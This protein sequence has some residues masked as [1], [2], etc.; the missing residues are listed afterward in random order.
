MSFEPLYIESWIYATLHDDDTLTEA[1]ADVEGNAPGYQQGVYMHL[2]P[3][4]DRVS[5]SAPQVPYIVVT[6]EDMGDESMAIE[7][8][9][10]LVEFD[11]QVTIWDSQNGAVAMDRLL[12]IADRVDTLLHKQ[13]ATQSGVKLFSRRIGTGTEIEPLQGGEVFYG[14][15]A[16][17]RFQTG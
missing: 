13:T 10:A 6:R 1:L 11:Y 3:Q 17:Y 4:I 15:F 5:Q 2:A 16:I 9:R 7:G 14:A 8:T 12:T